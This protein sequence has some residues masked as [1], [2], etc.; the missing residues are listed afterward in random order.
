MLVL[1]LWGC[2]GSAADDTAPVVP[3]FPH[4]R[5]IDAYGDVTLFAS[6]N[7]GLQS[8]RTIFTDAT[9][10]DQDLF[11]AVTATETGPDQLDITLSIDLT[12]GGGCAFSGQSNP[13]QGTLEAGSCMLP[14][15]Q[16]HVW[17]T[18]DTP[19]NFATGNPLVDNT[20]SL[21]GRWTEQ[22]GDHLL[23]GDGALYLRTRGL[24][25]TLGTSAALDPPARADWSDPFVHGGTCVHAGIF[26]TGTLV[27]GDATSCSGD[28]LEWGGDGFDLY[29]DDGARLS[30]VPLDTNEPDQ[31]IQG[32]P[33]LDAS[34]LH[35]FVGNV[36]FEHQRYELDFDNDRVSWTYQFLHTPEGQTA[37]RCQVRW[38][39]PLSDCQ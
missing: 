32:V 4:Y 11:W 10:A 30:F 24:N 35:A 12:G 1:L 34:R 18:L 15:P 27:E 22:L 17:F 31:R 19:A 28:A 7:P 26:G 16:G 21:F 29:I 9:S 38:E 37:T 33:S 13:F 39:G 3:A 25:S 20:T 23:T 14:T 6:D 8:G 5:N 36:T 2:F